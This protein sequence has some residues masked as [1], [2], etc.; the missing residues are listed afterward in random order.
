MLTFTL[1]DAKVCYRKEV[2]QT[3]PIKISLAAARVNAGLSQA[4]VA[5]T[6]KVSNKTI[7]N[8]ENGKAIP[9]FASL[10]TLAQIYKIPIDCILL[11]SNSLK[12][13]IEEAQAT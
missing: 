1:S 8:W 4:E 6:L 11:P 5:K 13:N 7:V 3:E 9:S 10:N 12:V 2:R